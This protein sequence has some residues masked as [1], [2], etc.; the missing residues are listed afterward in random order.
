MPPKLHNTLSYSVAGLVFL[1]FVPWDN[2]A[3]W[4][5]AALWVF[6]FARRSWEAQVVHRYSGRTIPASDYLVEYVYY[7][8]FAFWIAWSLRNPNWTLPS[9]LV[10][11]AAAIIFASGELGNTWAHLKL[12]AL[13]SSSG[14]TQRSIPRGGL[15]DWVSCPHYLFEITTWCGFLLLTQVLAS[16]LFLALGAAIVSSYAWSRHQRYRAEFDGNEGRELYPP[17]RKA[18]IPLLF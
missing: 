12:R 14:E 17:A 13:R 5:I 1:A 8:G 7:W 2:H 10:T 3:A 4:L 16:C 18:I 15:F 6:H 11:L 9:H